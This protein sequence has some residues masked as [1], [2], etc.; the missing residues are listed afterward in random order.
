MKSIQTGTTQS[1]HLL[2]VFSLTFRGSSEAVVLG[3]HCR[4]FGL[5]LLHCRYLGL[6]SCGPTH[7]F[8][9]VSVEIQTD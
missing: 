3:T 6:L 9:Q 7:L 8:H 5:Y 2:C 4:F 1:S